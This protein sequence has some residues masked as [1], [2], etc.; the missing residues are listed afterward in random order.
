M[1]E[2]HNGWT[3]WETAC[4]HLWIRGEEPSSKYWTWRAENL[5]TEDLRAALMLHYSGA[6]DD[7]EDLPGVF[8][9]LLSSSLLQ[10]NWQEIAEALREGMDEEGEA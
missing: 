5:D 1:S 6:M 2:E 7:M 10:V 8:R 3:N 9:E 4:V